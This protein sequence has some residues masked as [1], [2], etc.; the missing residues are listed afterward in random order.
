MAYGHRPSPELLDHVAACN[1]AEPALDETATLALRS[2]AECD[3][4]AL[5]TGC[6]P[7][8]EQDI[9]LPLIG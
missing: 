1:V 7:D 9:D 2:A 4:G 5:S 8:G 3:L 6:F